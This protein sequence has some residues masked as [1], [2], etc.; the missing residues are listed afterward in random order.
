MGSKAEYEA[1]KAAKLAARR[2]S[3]P[4]V[5]RTAKK[6]VGTLTVT[7]DGHTFRFESTLAAEEAAY[8]SAA[9]AR[10]TPMVISAKN[11]PPIADDPNAEDLLN[12]IFPEHTATQS[13]GY[14]VT[15][16][17]GRIIAAHA[18]TEDSSYCE[19][20]LRESRVLAAGEV[21]HACLFEDAGNGVLRCIKR[22]VYPGIIIP[23]DGWWDFLEDSHWADEDPDFGEFFG[24]EVGELIHS[25]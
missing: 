5:K 1:K 2:A 10:L 20:T 24:P 23:P 22:I 16:K 19:F 13:I 25:S 7:N 21:V 18:T 8:V 12:R 9:L 17:L 11:T 15:V 6:P 4:R 14:C 3:E